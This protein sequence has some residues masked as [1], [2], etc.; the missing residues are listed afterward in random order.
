[1]N[2]KQSKT[3]ARVLADPAPTDIPW[4]DIES[5]LEA[6]GVEVE[7]LSETRVAL[8]KG[9]HV[10][11]VQRP[12]PMPLAGRATVKDVAAFLRTVSR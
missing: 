2:T 4:S 9:R 12:H 11:I 5:L 6:V 7:S 8:V 10:M 1:M 3:R